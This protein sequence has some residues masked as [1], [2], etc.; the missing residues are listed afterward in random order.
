MLPVVVYNNPLYTGNSL[1][2]ALIAELMA[3]DGI[4]GLKQSEDDLGQLVEALRLAAAT[5]RNLCT[6]IDSQFYAALC[7][8]ASGIFSTAASIVP[9]A[10]GRGSWTSPRTGDHDEARS[11]STACYSR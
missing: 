8:G 1:S 5:G 4:V 7:V 9:G 11:S 6:G 2:P 10:D 3:I